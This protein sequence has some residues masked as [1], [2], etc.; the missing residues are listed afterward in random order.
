MHEPVRHVLC[1]SCGAQVAWVS[2]NRYRP[3]CS[4]RC[5]LADLGAWATEQY[6]VAGAG[7]E[8]GTGAAG[9][10]DDALKS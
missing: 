6:R 8:P 7:P 2:E 5:K 1:P 10:H 9:E 4:E 3:F